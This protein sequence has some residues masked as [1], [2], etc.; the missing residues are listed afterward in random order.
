MRCLKEKIIYR[1]LL[2][3]ATKSKYDKQA[4]YMVKGCGIKF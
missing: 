1:V 4:D 3:Y 2:N